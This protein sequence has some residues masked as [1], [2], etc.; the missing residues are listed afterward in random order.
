[1]I[2]LEL[3]NVRSQGDSQYLNRQTKSRSEV[4]APVKNIGMSALVD[5]TPRY[6]YLFLCTLSE[7]NDERRYP[8]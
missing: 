6:K 1:M 7:V 8:I 5:G 3:L 2:D 4:L